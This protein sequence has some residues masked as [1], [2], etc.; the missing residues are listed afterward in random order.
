LL[1]NGSVNTSVATEDDAT[2][3]GLLEKKHAT[4]EKPRD[5]IF[6]VLCP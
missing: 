6:H 2:V 1:S 4:I 5:D 3:E